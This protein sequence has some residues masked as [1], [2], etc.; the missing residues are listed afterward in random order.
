V[1]F[2]ELMGLTNPLLAHGSHSRQS[3]RA[4]A[5]TSSVSAA[6]RRCASNSTASST[7]Y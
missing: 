3:Q 1:A 2:D 5:A 7:S 6:I 4:R